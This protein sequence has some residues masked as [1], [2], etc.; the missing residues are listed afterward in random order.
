MSA[1]RDERVEGHE[2]LAKRRLQR[3]LPNVIVERGRQVDEGLEAVGA[4]T[5]GEHNRA[6][7]G[8][9]ATTRRPSVERHGTELVEHTSETATCRGAMG[10]G[11][12]TLTVERGDRLGADGVDAVDD[13]LAVAA[14]QAPPERVSCETRGLGGERSSRDVRQIV[15]RF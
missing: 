4:P 7:V 12:G 9:R 15:G 14:A 1:G 13:S 6:I 5:A 10:E 11:D 2:S 3:L 8:Q